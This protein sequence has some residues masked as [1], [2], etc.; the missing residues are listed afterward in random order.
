M[1]PEE[2]PFAI[3]QHYF[4]RTITFSMVGQVK[5]IVGKFLILEDAS[6]IAETGRFMETI[7]DG[8]L[9]EV[10][11]LG[12]AFLNIESIVD[13]FEWKHNTHKAQR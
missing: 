12:K 1:K 6:W 10:E 4:F 11:P 2:I 9:N 7:R 13:A 3:G 8:S 5:E